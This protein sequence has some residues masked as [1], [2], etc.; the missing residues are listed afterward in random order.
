MKLL[1]QPTLLSTGVYLQIPVKITLLDEAIIR[2]N[3]PEEVLTFKY[4]ELGNRF[5]IPWRKIKGKLRRLV[6]E[7]QRGLNIEPNCAL[8]DDLCM[9]CPTCFLFGGTG[10]TSSADVPY[11]ILT[12]IY[13]E[14]FISESNVESIT[15]YTG[16]AVS[17]KYQDTLRRDKTGKPT[18]SG[19]LLS[20][21]TVPKETVFTGVVTLKD[22]TP[23]TVSILVDNIQ[24]LSRIGASSG[25]WG[26]VQTSIE[27]YYLADREVCSGYLSL[28]NKPQPKL[29]VSSS[30][31]K[32]PVVNKA[33]KTLDKQV[34]GLIKSLTAYK[35]DKSK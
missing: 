12:R 1:D 31:Q 35:K 7:K 2:S 33:Y 5:I 34:K 6:L 24:R 3:E 10:E 30:G 8:K 17:E 19:A 11:N 16:N 32:I 27:G 29:A 14:T 22:P 13:G 20:I 21:L 18:G 4:K 9:Q 23:E 25:I 15:P 28:A 26:R